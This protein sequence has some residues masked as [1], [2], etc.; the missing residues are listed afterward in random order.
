MLARKLLDMEQM[1]VIPLLHPLSVKL[2]DQSWMEAKPQINTLGKYS[3][4]NI[5]SNKQHAE[6]GCT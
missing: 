2:T 1:I 6:E 3:S 5:A 4:H